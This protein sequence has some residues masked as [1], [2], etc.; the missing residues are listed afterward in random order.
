MP[1]TGVELLEAPERDLLLL[2]VAATAEEVELYRKDGRALRVLASKQLITERQ[3]LS[4][5]QALRRT[6]TRYLTDLRALSRQTAHPPVRITSG[7][8]AGSIHTCVDDP[9]DRQNGADRPMLTSWNVRPTSP[10]PSSPP[11]RPGQANTEPAELGGVRPAEASRGHDT[12]QRTPCCRGS[13]ARP[14][15]GPEPPTQLGTRS[16]HRPDTRHILSITAAAPT[17]GV[18]NLG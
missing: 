5:Q 13:W 6:W 10:R 16:R 14:S 1:S 7:K 17:R 2:G 3:N 12:Y 11:A 8:A 15:N 9:R 4:V 18:R